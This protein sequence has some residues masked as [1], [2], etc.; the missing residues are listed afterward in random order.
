MTRN[1]SGPASACMPVSRTSV[2]RREDSGGSV[3]EGLAGPSSLQVRCES[4]S[5]EPTR[6]GAQRAFGFGNG[7][8][9]DVAGRPHLVEEAHRLAAK[10]ASDGE[11]RSGDRR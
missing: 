1:P 4:D 2:A 7:A 8:G 6:A 9:D 10:D 11:I 3:S 5:S